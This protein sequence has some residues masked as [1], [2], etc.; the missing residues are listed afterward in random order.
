MCGIVGTMRFGGVVDRALLERQ[1]DTLRHRGP[2]SEGLWCSPDG[3]VG[4]GHRRLAIID[5]SPGGHQPMTDPVTGNVITFNGEI[6]NYRELRAELTERGCRW[7]SQSDTEVILAAWRIWGTACLPRLHGMFAFALYESATQRVVLARDRAGEKPLFMHRTPSQLT[8]ASEV[9]A[10]LADP[11][12]PR[13]LSIG[14]LNEY[15]AYGYVTGEQTMFADIQRLAPGSYLEVAVDGSHIVARRYWQLPT[16]A[17]HR[18]APEDLV[19]R[20]ESTLRQAVRRQ[21]VADVPVGVLLSGGVDSSLVTALAA[22]ESPHP[23]RTYTVRFP[24][25]P[26]FDEGP[27]A[28][29]VATHFGTEHTELLADDAD[30]DMLHALAVQFDDPIADSSMVPTYL[31]SRAIRT[32]A[33]VAIGGDGGDELFGGYLRYPALLRQEQWRQRM[34][35]MLRRPFAAALAAAWPASARGHGVLEAMTGDA[36]DGIAAA[37]RL[38]RRSERR[39]LSPALQLLYPDRLKRPELLRTAVHGTGGLVGRATAVDFTTYMVDDVLVKV[40]RASMLTSLEV[41]APLLDAEMVRFAFEEVPDELKATPS[42]RKVL[43]RQLAA[44]WLPSSLDLTRKQGFAMPVAASLRGPW[45]PLRDIAMP[46]VMKHA[47][48]SR[49]VNALFTRLDGGGER[50]G[51]HVGEAC[52]AL[53]ML[54][55]WSAHYQITDLV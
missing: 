38:L 23:V 39:R 35:G 1:R 42:S 12:C 4:F 22:A 17:P 19:M 41:R 24:D 2:D 9:K 30:A 43:L 36:G 54:Q 7:H 13:R 16:A 29:H 3:R 52:F 50:G 32:H 18:A 47:I 20:L 34:P 37:G 11:A 53:Q 21:L 40:D 25:A 27:F 48:D 14:S 26:R 49:A 46:S 33:T 44:R 55:L 10:L 5:L 45:R 51:D 6:Y 28:R 8:F 15:L 31:V